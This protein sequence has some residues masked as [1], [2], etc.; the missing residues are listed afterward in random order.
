MKRRSRLTGSLTGTRRQC[1]ERRWVQGRSRLTG[2]Q[3]NP[4]YF[5]PVTESRER[6]QFNSIQFNSISAEDPFPAF[7]DGVNRE[8]DCAFAKKRTT[9]SRVEQESGASRLDAG[10]A[11]SAYIT[12]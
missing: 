2:S 7:R 4:T 12:H 6:I 1:C 9:N 10:D 11:A 5:I 8:V 3:S